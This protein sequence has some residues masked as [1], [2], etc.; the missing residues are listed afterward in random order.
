MILEMPIDVVWNPGV[1]VVAVMTV[2]S[3]TH[4]QNPQQGY[5]G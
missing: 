2:W 1:S 4:S 5:G 3:M